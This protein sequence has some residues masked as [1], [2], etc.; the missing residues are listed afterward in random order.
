MLALF[1]YGYL[2]YERRNGHGLGWAKYVGA[3]ALTLGIVP[4]TAVAMDP[5]N[6]A[7]LKVASGANVLGEAA[8]HELLVKWKGLNLTRSLFPLVGAAFGF[9][10]LVG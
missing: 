2:A 3:A 8:V 5:T 6:Q 7:L 9:W 10:G 4:F 1:G